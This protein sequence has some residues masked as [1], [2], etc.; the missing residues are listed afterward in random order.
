VTVNPT[1]DVTNELRNEDQLVTGESSTYRP[2]A[3]LR[4]AGGKGIDVSRVI[5]NLG[6]RSVA[7]GFL[8]GF[9][10][11]LVEGLLL[12]D[13]LELDFNVIRD[14]TRTNVIIV[15]QDPKNPNS[16]FD[17]R[18]N[19]PGPR[20]QPY[21]FLELCKK[22]RALSRGPKERLPTHAAICG[23]LCKDMQATSY[24]ALVRYFKEMGATVA[25]D[26]S[27]PALKETL[28]YKPRPD[29]IKPNSDEFY[30]L[31]NK[32]LPN[33][34]PNATG[35]GKDSDGRDSG[36]R[37]P[38]WQDILGKVSEFRRAYPDVNALITLGSAGM[39]LWR[40][41]E[42]LHA[43]LSKEKQDK[44]VVQ[45]TVG[46]GDTAL[47]GMLYELDQRRD[48]ATG[49]TTALAAASAAVE[50]K[51]TESPTKEAV[52]AFIPGVEIH[53]HDL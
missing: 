29:I 2:Q 20:V 43:R 10:G 31:L 8:G 12:Q 34:E 22:I 14:E 36:E 25:L 37:T 41:G 19:S 4:H 38:F 42:L 27:G 48:W 46:A 21:E 7:M 26:T 35:C 3:Q 18:F 50:L 30:E 39:L 11:E 47:A 5:R 44:L 9:T 51:G 17:Y 52:N 15:V 49:L 45:S 33:G 13:G 24:V 40:D 28:R 53:R 32:Q 16:K 23:S 1:I 6:G